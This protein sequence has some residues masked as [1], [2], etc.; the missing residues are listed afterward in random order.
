[1]LWGG[2]AVGGTTYNFD[3]TDF[4]VTG[5][6]NVELSQS[7]SPFLNLTCIDQTVNQVSALVNERLPG[8]VKTLSLEQN[9]AITKRPLSGYPASLF[10][11]LIVMMEP[12]H[13]ELVVYV[14][15]K[16]QYLYLLIHM[17]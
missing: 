11:N 14:Q 12:Q 4:V 17:V 2:V 13:Q 6:S 15:Y 1:M 8:P 16:N 5:G 7:P 10:Y 3:N 9:K